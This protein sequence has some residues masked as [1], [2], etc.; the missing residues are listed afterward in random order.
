V[1]A[2]GADEV[3][4]AVREELRK[5]ATQ[6]KIF[7]SGGVTSPADPIWMRQF[8]AEEI[9]AAVYE[10][11]TRR[12]YVMAHCHTSDSAQACIAAG[13]R[14]IE[15]GSDLDAPTAKMIV[16]AGAFVVPTM[17]VADTALRHGLA[18]GLKAANL[19]KLEG[20]SGKMYRSLEV[21]RSHGVK[22]G[23]GTDLPG[24]FGERQNQEFRLRSAVLPAVEILRSATS[25]N[26]SLLQMEAEIGCIKAGASADILV[27]NGD[28][29]RDI[30]VL[31]EPDKG[32][33]LIMARGSIIKNL[34]D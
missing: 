29:T 5:G 31:A 17:V 34:L 7:A 26:A 10:A 3:R 9:G 19:E 27:V 25:V 14:S 16:A 32:L 22:L 20:I 21:C 15:H 6:I 12:T 13:V 30:S 33:S 8:T 2:D 1:I 18:M 28:P 11:S 24:N 4:R 23:F